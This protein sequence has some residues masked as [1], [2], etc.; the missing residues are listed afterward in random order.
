V[1]RILCAVDGSAAADEA[2]DLAIS[3]CRATGASLDVVVAWRRPRFLRGTPPPLP[4]ELETP[5]RADEVLRSALGRAASAGVEAR[6]HVAVGDAAHAIVATAEE[7]DAA[8]VVVGRRGR[9]A[10]AGA[11]LG[12]VSQRVVRECARPVT[13]VG[14]HDSDP[15]AT[16]A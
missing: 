13:V 9:G 4:L 16:R 6:P 5:D 14:R 1:N 8:L 7:L 12:S 15:P 3:L 10:V 2:L 11:L